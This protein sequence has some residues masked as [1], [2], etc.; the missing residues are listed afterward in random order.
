MDEQRRKALVLEHHRR[1]NAGDLDGLLALYAEG[2]TFEDPVGSGR[3]SGR[4]AL[5]AHFARS[6]E[7]NLRETPGEP[8]AGQD[9]RHALVAVS[10]VM[11]YLPKGP[12]FA[13]RGWLTAPPEPAGG[14][15]AFAYVLMIRTAGDGL[16]DD[17]RAFWGRSDL[18]CAG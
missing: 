2:V 18:E 4:A 6:I 13:E 5:R 12:D 8:V 16:I 9:A 14:R 7:G 1:V 11:D 3:Q 10:A 17:L 15:L